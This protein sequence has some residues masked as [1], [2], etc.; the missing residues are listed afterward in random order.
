MLS[1]FSDRQVELELSDEIAL[2]EKASGF[3]P[4]GELVSLPSSPARCLSARGT[5]KG[6]MLSWFYWVSVK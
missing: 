4:T 3:A 1:L 2:V 5:A 6:V